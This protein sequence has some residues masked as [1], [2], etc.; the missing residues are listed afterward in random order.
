[1]NN[2]YNYPWATV[3]F[4]ES[5]ADYDEEK[6]QQDAGKERK[7]AGSKTISWECRLSSLMND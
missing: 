4:S 5:V 6:R 2:R 7:Q 1:M 3:G